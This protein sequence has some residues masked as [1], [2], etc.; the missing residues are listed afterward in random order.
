MEVFQKEE[1]HI[2]APPSLSLYRWLIQVEFLDTFRHFPHMVLLPLKALGLV[3]APIHLY[4]AF[5]TRSR[6]V[7]TFSDAP[8]PKAAPGRKE[9]KPSDSSI[10]FLGEPLLWIFEITKP[11]FN[12]W[13][14]VTRQPLFSFSCTVHMCVC[15]CSPK[16][17]K[18]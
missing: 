6:R 11:R 15:V 2:T 16:T 1:L 7:Y 10:S 13:A 9:K 5:R 4:L 18:Q 8:L 3:F 14:M 17:K 12:F